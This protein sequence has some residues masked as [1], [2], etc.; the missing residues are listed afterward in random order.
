MIAK[1]VTAGVLA[2]GLVACAPAQTKNTMPEVAPMQS[3]HEAGIVTLAS[4]H[5][6]DVT[7][8][9]LA[10]AVKKKGLRVFARIDHYQNAKDMSLDMR[11]NT[12]LIFGS[13]KIGSP[14]MN[15][16][17]TMG[18]DLPVKALA[19]QDKDGNVFLSYNHPSY[20]KE[21][22]G[23]KTAIVPLTKM[24]KALIGL[25]ARATSE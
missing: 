10:A 20:L 17:P 3:L 8:D 1:F 6:V 24:G 14:L 5:S 19:W 22:H 16:S 23:I 11:P 15:E 18:L 25:S 21:R 12:L 4:A 9:R 7:I 13:P 2:A